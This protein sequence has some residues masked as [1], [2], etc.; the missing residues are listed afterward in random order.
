VPAQAF[1]R[2]LPKSMAADRKAAHEQIGDGVNVAFG[3]LSAAD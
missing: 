2:L 1:Q 3:D